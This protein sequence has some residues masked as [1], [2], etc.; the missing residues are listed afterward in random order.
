MDTTILPAEVIRM[1]L[2]ASEPRSCANAAATCRS[3]LLA[4]E[5]TYERLR[6]LAAYGR[7]GTVRLVLAL[8]SGSAEFTGRILPNV[9][10]AY[11][12]HG[13]AA[14]KPGGCRYT[15]MLDALLVGLGDRRWI[16]AVGHCRHGELFR[17]TL[18]H[19][20]HA[21]GALCARSA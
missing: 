11:V 8:S 20:L 21:L 10:V 19:A 18:E 4:S 15:E 5:A 12:A 14:R 3:F 9:I 7:I 17:S 6:D 13:V 1:I 16:D 2:G